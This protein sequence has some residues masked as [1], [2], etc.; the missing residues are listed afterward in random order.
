MSAAAIRF[1]LTSTPEWD[2]GFVFK[3]Q[4]DQFEEELLGKER[5]PGEYLDLFLDVISDPTLA[6]RKGAWN[7]VVRMYTDREKLDSNQLQR[8]LDAAI[9][10]YR[11]YRDERMQ[12]VIC[13]FIA[14][15]YNANTALFAL[16]K[17]SCEAA[18]R[19]AVGALKGALVTII[20]NTR[21]GSPERERALTLTR[22]LH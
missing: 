11:Y 10:G 6:S 20:G 17:M 15:S 8:I 16:E 2:A 22:A 4:A 12:L 9:N 1:V 5:V 21:E 3:Q 18:E 13:D 19:S 14:R 7:F